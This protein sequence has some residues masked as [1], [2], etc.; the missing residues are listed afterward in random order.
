MNNINEYSEYILTDKDIIVTK[1]DLNGIITYVNDDLIRI[2]GYSEEELI[3]ANHRIFRHPYMPAQVFSNLWKTIMGECTWRG[4]IK[5]KTKDG[6]CYWVHADVTPLYENNKLVG[7][8]SVRIKPSPDEL[9]AA[10]YYYDQMNAG[11]FKDKLLY[12]SIVRNNI[13]NNIKHLFDNVHLSTKFSLIIGLCIAAIVSFTTIDNLELSELADSHLEIIYQIQ[14][15]TPIK[16]N[17]I[18]SAPISEKEAVE[19]NAYVSLIDMQYRNTI[20]VSFLIIVLIFLYAIVLY[21]IKRPLIE[22]RE[23]LK[24]LSNGVYRIPIKYRSKNEIGRMM[25]ALRTTSVRLG[26]DVANEKKIN[27]QIIKAHEKNQLLNEQINQLQRIESIGRMTAGIAHNFN[28]ILGSIIGFNQMNMLAGEDC[29]DEDLKQEI[30]NNAQQVQEASAKAV[31]LVKRMMSY[32]GQR[33]VS[34]LS[35]D[36]KPTSEVIDD[37][38]KMM[39]PC[40]TSLHQIHTN[41]KLDYTINID[42]YDLHQILTNLIVNAKDAMKSYGN[43]EISLDIKN[44]EHQIC[45]SCLTYLNGEFIELQ[46]SDNGSGISDDII[47]HIFDPFFTTKAVGEGTGLGLSTVSGMIHECRGHIVVETETEGPNHGTKFKLLFPYEHH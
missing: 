40:L 47:T 4:V 44:I 29:S 24:E 36:I 14:N 20:R 9:I 7:Y 28:N 37:V 42:Q 23:G 30:L 41:I 2:T 22:A 38:A 26:Y 34:L 39:R 33:P 43:I 8:M 25:E 13:F 11:E 3:G 6:S 19:L 27:A 16:T 1:T 18:N 17:Y 32:A 35:H 21:S 15:D 31:E 46:V 5:N 45:N 10:K 12:G